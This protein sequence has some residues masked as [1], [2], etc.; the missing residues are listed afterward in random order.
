LARAAIAAGAQGLFFETHPDPPRAL[1]DPTTQL[2]LAGIY[3]FLDEMVEWK[4]MQSR[5]VNRPD[6]IGSVEEP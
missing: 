3:P 2:P 1:S 4:R 6:P 5:W